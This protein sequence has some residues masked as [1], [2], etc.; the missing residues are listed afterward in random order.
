MKTGKKIRAASLAMIAFLFITNTLMAQGAD[1]ARTFHRGHEGL[2]SHM[3]RGM[4]GIPNLTDD[5]KAKIKAQQ[6]AFG[7]EALPLQNQ[8][9]E[10]RAH[11]RTLQTAQAYDANAVNATIDDIAKTESQLMKKHAANHEAI[12][13]LLN[14]EQRLAFDSNKGFRHGSVRFHNRHRQGHRD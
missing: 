10:K 1:S 2:R 8:L 13:K 5:Q 3:E 14:D 11:L 9:E 4:M 6:I 7:K 12:R